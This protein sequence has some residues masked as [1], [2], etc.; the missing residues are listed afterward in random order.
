MKKVIYAGTAQ[1]IAN[2]D[3]EKLIKTV[4]INELVDSLRDAGCAVVVFTPAQL[5][6]ADRTHVEERLNDYGQ[7]II[8][9]ENYL[10]SQIKK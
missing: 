7:G 6:N 9:I 1:E 3:W 5:K 2:G 10:N 8:D 4:D